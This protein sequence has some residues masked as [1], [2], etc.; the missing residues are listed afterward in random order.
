[1][2]Y[3]ASCVHCDAETEA[4]VYL[5]GKCQMLAERIEAPFCA[6]CSEPFSGEIAS[7]FTC[8]NCRT[9]RFHFECAVSPVR[10]RGMARKL[11]LRFKYSGHH[12]LRRV[13]TDWLAEALED[14]RIKRQ[15][16]D[17]LVPVPLHPRRKRERGFNQAQSLCELL[18]RRAG[19]P[20]WPALRRVRYTETQTRL[21]RAERNHNVRGAFQHS[22]RW[23]LQGARLLLVDDVFTT[24]STVDECARVL[25]HAGAASVRVL[26]VARR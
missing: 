8:S 23:P 20:I 18:S 7:S 16:A 25:R 21:T 13:L 14:E 4:G 12:Y 5:C 24:G 17:A 19:L 6:V 26:T 10:A 11:I 9:Q 1:M 2:L 3:P 22:P 15:P